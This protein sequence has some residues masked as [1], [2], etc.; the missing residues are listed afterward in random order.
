MSLRLSDL[1][2]CF[3]GVIPSIIAT[4]A[5]DG[6]PNISYLSHVVRVDETHVA[7]SNQ[8]FAKTA[9]NVRANTKATLMLVDGLTGAQFTLDIAFC[10]SID[11]GAL[12]DRIA[13]QLKASSAQVGMAEVMRLRSADLF[14]VERIESVPGPIEA[15][16]AA[17]VARPAVDLGVLADAAAAVG[18]QPGA[19]E[20]IDGLLDAVRRVLGYGTAIVLLRDCERG[21]LVTTGSIGYA[22]SGVGSE[23]VG[24][25]GLIGE[26]ALRGQVVKLSDM[27]RLR[28]FGGAIAAE[29]LQSEDVTRSVAF[30][31]LP[32]AMSQVAVPM[33]A[34]GAVLGVLFAESTA[35]LAFRDEEEAALR[36]LA[37]QA[38]AALWASE[39]EAAA[40][41]GGADAA[42]AAR[43][44][45]RTG[46]GIRIVHHGFDDSVFVNGTYMVK[47]VAGMLLRMMVEW[48]LA[49]GRSAFTNRELRLAAGA[50]MPEIK[51]NLEARLL[52]LRR[53]LDEKQ[54]PI[55]LV[56]T[57]RGLMRLE[58]E[59]SPTLEAGGE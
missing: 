59:G 3:E 21:C 45:A 18:A 12:F 15:G 36:L 1:G 14:R 54:A 31:Q 5:A 17:P 46:H 30:P 7:I 33:I 29:T 13:G 40:E 6:M 55:R 56:R 37:A 9:A 42:V 52:L 16:G 51:D 27:S 58:M 53:R 32:G 43:G 19:G 34:R 2:A 8:F 44:P 24:D 57:G 49:E 48:H 28:R 20:I 26:A 4:A 41:A 38:A 35:R 22:P 39:R 10:R 11:S 25:A 23:V 47:G 50:R